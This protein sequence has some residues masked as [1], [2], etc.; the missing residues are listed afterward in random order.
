MGTHLLA[1]SDVALPHGRLFPLGGVG[2]DTFVQVDDLVK[3]G[4]L[5]SPVSPPHGV[6]GS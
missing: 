4:V 6:T 2:R 5:C 1:D 3:L